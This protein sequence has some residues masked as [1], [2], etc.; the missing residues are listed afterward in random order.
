MIKTIHAKPIYI[1][2]TKSINVNSDAIRLRTRWSPTTPS[3]G[4]Y[5]SY[6]MLF[7]FVVS[8]AAVTLLFVAGVS[9]TGFV[10]LSI[11]RASPFRSVCLVL[12]ILSLVELG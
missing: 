8:F 4:K 12:A 2:Q 1:Q 3:G 9:A 6:R 11:R 5:A 7:V 10:A